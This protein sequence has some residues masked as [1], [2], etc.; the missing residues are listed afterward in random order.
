MRERNVIYKYIHI[1]SRIFIRTRGTP[2]DI[3]PT[4]SRI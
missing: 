1:N 4:T 2:L 3:Q